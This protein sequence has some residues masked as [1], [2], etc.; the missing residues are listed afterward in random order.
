MDSGSYDSVL[1]YFPSFRILHNLLYL[2]IDRSFSS[3]GVHD[4]YDDFA[5]TV[6]G[7]M[8]GMNAHLPHAFSNIY[9]AS[10]R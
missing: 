5:C 10:Y 7:S 2:D 8:Y 3:N 1:K 6:T 4:F 9:N